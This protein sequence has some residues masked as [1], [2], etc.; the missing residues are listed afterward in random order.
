MD[1]GMTDPQEMQTA[2]DQLAE[3]LAGARFRAGLREDPKGAATTAG[4]NVDTLPDGLLATLGLMSDQELQ[5]VARV[6]QSFKGS[7]RDS[8]SVA[9][10]F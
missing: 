3:E 8:A 9:I 10:L 4:I 6:Q 7:I 2:L 5:I 1:A